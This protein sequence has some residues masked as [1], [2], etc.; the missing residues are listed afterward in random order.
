MSADGV[1]PD[2]LGE[3]VERPIVRLFTEYGGDHLHWF[4]IGLATSMAARFLSLVPP[5]VLGVA[6]DA[7]FY[8]KRAYTLPHLPDA[9]VPTTRTPNRLNHR[10]SDL[11]R[12]TA[13]STG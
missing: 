4:A 10:T 6:L 13:P 3:S 8:S 11:F 7:V 9:W 2:E 1:D 12:A 5:L